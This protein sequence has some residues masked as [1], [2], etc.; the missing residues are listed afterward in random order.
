MIISKEN[1]KIYLI[2]ENFKVVNNTYYSNILQS[3]PQKL[4]KISFDFKHFKNIFVF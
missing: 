3:Y 1:V 4:L 2:I